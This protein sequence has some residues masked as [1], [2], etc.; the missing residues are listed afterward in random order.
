MKIILIALLSIVSV[1]A[2]IGGYMLMI[3]PS[4]SSLKMSTSELRI[5]LFADFLLR[6]IILFLVVGSGSL[7][8]LIWVL[9]DKKNPGI[10]LRFTGMILCGWITIE[11][12]ILQGVTSLHI[13]YLGVGVLLM[14]MKFR[15][16]VPDSAS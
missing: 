13:F 2:L 14:S 4:G 7:F 3:D 12:I 11:M 8:A 16:R 10:P 1:P 5:S 6:G 15:P 9:L